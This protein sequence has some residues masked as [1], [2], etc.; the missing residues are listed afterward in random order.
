VRILYT[1]IRLSYPYD[2]QS[3]IVLKLFFSKERTDLFED[4]ISNLGERFGR[5]FADHC[6]EA[7][8]AKLFF[9]GIRGFNNAI[10]V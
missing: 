1:G 5:V 2:H 7:L 10:R 4:F 8:L 9:R 3:E 6:A